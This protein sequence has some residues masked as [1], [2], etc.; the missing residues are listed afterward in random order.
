MAGKEDLVFYTAYEEFYAMAESSRAFSLYC[1]RAFGADFSQDGFSDREQVDLML[2]LSGIGPRSKVL[3]MGCGNGK[4]M[5]YAREKTGA[6]VFGFDYSENAIRAA[7][8]RG[9]SREKFRVGVLGEISYP[10]SS[11]DAVFSMDT[12]Y[13]V[14]DVEE[15]VR[16]ILSWLRPG[17][18]FLCGYEEG[19]VAP[20]TGSVSESVPVK[21]F[22]KLGIPYRAIDYTEETY[23]MLRR[24]REAVLSLKK[25]FCR[26]G[27]GFWYKVILEQTSCARGSFEKF[28]EKNARYL[29]VAEAESVQK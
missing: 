3:D 21:A 13:F 25:E 26:E 17:G 18:R 24:K 11:F 14:P 16:N 28:A 12:L 20:K 1:Q 2:R 29:F 19:D 4:M 27:N 8:E 15:A 10:P 9:L 7:W 5:A 22:Q 6:E 23:R